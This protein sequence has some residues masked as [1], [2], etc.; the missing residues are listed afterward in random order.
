MFVP[1]ILICLE[2]GQCQALPGPI[3]PTMEQCKIIL[4]TGKHEVQ[5]TLPTNI[6]IQDAKCVQFSTPT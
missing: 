4:E 1:I 5:N 3:A 2:T 6:K